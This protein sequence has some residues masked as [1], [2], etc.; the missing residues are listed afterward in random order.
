MSEK[1]LPI[2]HKRELRAKMKE[3]KPLIQGGAI[4]QL[5]EELGI[6]ANLI[7]DVVGGRRWNLDVIEG[8]I[9]IGQQNLKRV[10]AANQA[11]DKIIE[12]NRKAAK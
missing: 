11:M 12:A 6:S 1:K 9:K 2:Q 8:L 4:K 5:A 7:Y 3:L 10:E